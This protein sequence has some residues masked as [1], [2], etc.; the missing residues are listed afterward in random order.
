MSPVGTCYIG[1]GSN[2]GERGQHIKEAIQALSAENDIKVIKVSSI[3]ESFPLE[4]SHGDNYL[5]AAAKIETSLSCEQLLNAVT[6]IEEKLGR[7]KILKTTPVF[8]DYFSLSSDSRTM[9]Q[10]LQKM[11]EQQKSK[12]K[13]TP[14]K[15][16][17]FKSI[18][19]S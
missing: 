19:E 5:N 4:G 10:Q 1:L 13:K 2:L 9:K 18:I 14:R 8:A 17:N 12:G 15:S 7:T 3:E 16:S 11:F 6:G